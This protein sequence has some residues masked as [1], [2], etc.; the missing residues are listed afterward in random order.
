[1]KKIFLILP[2]IFIFS[3][4]LFLVQAG[5]T[6]LTGTEQAKNFYQ[7]AEDKIIN[8]VKQFI[9][10]F[11]KEQEQEFIGGVQER[12]QEKVGQKTGEL[13]EEVKQE[14]KTRTKNWIKNWF[15]EK[16]AKI[17]E[18]LNPLKIKIQEGSDWLRSWFSRSEE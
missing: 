12:V 7:K 17:E 14:V 16:L 9:K 2:L 11:G 4:N 3:F 8:P 18:L 10:S 13:K 5:E 6:G 15:Q 1:M